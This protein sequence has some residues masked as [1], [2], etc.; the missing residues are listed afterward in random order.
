M[1]WAM[2]TEVMAI[3]IIVMSGGGGGGGCC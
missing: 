1:A 2:V 3:S